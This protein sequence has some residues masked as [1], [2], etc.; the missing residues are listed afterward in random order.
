MIDRLPGSFIDDGT[1][2]LQP[3]P[4]DEAMAMRHGIKKTKTGAASSSQDKK[5][6][7]ENAEKQS[8][9]PG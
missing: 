2:N 9:D 8:T 1:G 6:V 3:N 5:E 4:D 7:M